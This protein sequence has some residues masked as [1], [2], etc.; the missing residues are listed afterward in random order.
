[1]NILTNEQLMRRGIA[2]VEDALR[3]GPVHLVKR[4]RPVAV[5]VTEAEFARLTGFDKP[6]ARVKKMTPPNL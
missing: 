4:N 6:A 1:M 3:Y 2:A 5:A